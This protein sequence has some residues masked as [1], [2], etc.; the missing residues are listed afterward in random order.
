MSISFQ[1]SYIEKPQNVEVASKLLFISFK[2]NLVMVVLDLFIT[3]E[4]FSLSSLIGLFLVFW[5]YWALITLIGL[6]HKKALLLFT[7]LVALGWLFVLLNVF[8]ELPINDDLDSLGLSEYWL[9]QV[10]DLSSSIM[11]LIALYL[12]F[13]KTPYEWFKVKAIRPS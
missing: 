4:L 13:Q 12:C 2:I 8:V 1:T 7:A 11:T 6:G 9:A 10:I 3:G 5:L